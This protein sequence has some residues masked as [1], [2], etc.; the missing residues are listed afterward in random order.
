MM[1][2]M[3]VISIVIVLVLIRIRLF[4]LIPFLVL[5]FANAIA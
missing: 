3:L 1:N 2:I 4:S 5:I